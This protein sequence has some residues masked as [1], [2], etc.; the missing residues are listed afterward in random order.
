MDERITQPGPLDPF[1]RLLS[2][3][4]VLDSVGVSKSSLYEMIKDPESPFPGPIKI[5]GRSMWIEADVILW[6]AD[7]VRRNLGLSD[8]L[9]EYRLRL[10]AA[11]DMLGDEC[12]NSIGGNL[13]QPQAG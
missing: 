12:L 1:G 9:G 11:E 7:V 13:H 6:K 4:S 10:R 8:P 2:L 3:R 5:G